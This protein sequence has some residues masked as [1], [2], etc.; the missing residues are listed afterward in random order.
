MFL[1]AIID[2]RLGDLSDGFTLGELELR[3]LEIDNRFAKGFAVFAIFNGQ[4]QRRFHLRKAL[5][6]NIE[7]LLRELFHQL[8]KALARL[9]TEECVSGHFHIIKKQLGRVLRVHP[10]LIENTPAAKT[11]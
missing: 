4:L 8:D 3:V 10:D 5:H 7:P 1:R 2:E 11:V 9:F 6:R